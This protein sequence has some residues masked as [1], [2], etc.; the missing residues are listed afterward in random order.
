VISQPASK[1]TIEAVSKTSD[2]PK[3]PCGRLPARL[4]AE[5]GFDAPSAFEV[6]GSGSSVVVELGEG[7][8]G[9][10]VGEGLIDAFTEGLV[11]EFTEGLGEKVIEEFI[12]GLGEKVIEEFIEGLGEKVIEEFIEGLGEKVIEEFDEGLGDSIEFDEGLGDST[13]G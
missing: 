4:P 5:E 2:N 11:E 9:E 7:L 8:G 10:L 6:D 12:E 3:I 13:A 1:R